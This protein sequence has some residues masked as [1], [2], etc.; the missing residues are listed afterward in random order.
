[1]KASQDPVGGCLVSQV[2]ITLENISDRAQYL[3]TRQTLKALFDYG[4][5]PIGTQREAFSDS[6]V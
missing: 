3:N 1:L 6:T 2:L 5:I 4:V